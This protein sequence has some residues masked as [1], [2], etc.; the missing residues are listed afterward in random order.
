MAL[1]KM[2]KGLFGLAVALVAV[3]AV[4]YAGLRYLENAVVEAVRTWAAQTPEGMKVQLGDVIY[5]LPKNRLVLKDARIDY[6][7]QESKSFASVRTLTLENP[8]TTLLSLLG[9]PKTEIKEAELPVADAIVA[10]GIA[11]GPEPDITQTE[12]AVSGI[13]VDAA[14]L[15]EVLASPEPKDAVWL[16]S[17][18]LSYKESSAKG[19]VCKVILSKDETLTA[20]IAQTHDTGFAKGH[21][22]VSSSRDIRMFM[23]GQEVLSI[24]EFGFE[25]MN[26]PSREVMGKLMALKPDASEK[27]VLPVVEELFASP[28]PLIGRFTVQN[29]K[30]VFGGL[31]TATLGK[32]GYSNTSTSPYGFETTVEHLKFPL[33]FVPEMQTLS[34]IGLSDID[35]SS[36]LALT[37]P[38]KDGQFVSVASFGIEQLGTTD[39]SLSGVLPKNV[40]E[41]IAR[42]GS[43]DATPE[44]QAALEAEL[45]KE[46]KVGKV[47]LGYADEGLLGRLALLGQKLFG[48][49]LEAEREVYKKFVE[50]EIIGTDTPD[51][52]ALGKFMEFADRPGAI[53]MSFAPAEPMSLEA[54]D[55][56]PPSQLVPAVEVSP[57]PRTLQEIVAELSK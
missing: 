34:L 16:L 19:I 8:G 50:S 56:L 25:N 17:Y 13:R 23:K 7:Y 33:S 32:L 35:M 18:G 39:F 10:E 40:F 22:D 11:I 54:I 45:L 41:K 55:A 4:G 36:S 27:E 20:E 14:I 42:L 31:G 12:Y 38:N 9:D 28:N 37:T 53:R 43:Q 29:V 51:Q 44:E 21:L 2:Q 1:S 6:M 46:I 48:M 5:S 47:E 26:M 52:K 3:V 49:S 24:A 57:G 30:A 15:K